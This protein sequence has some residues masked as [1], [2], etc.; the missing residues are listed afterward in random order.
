[1][2][3]NIDAVFVLTNFE[4]HLEYAKMAMDQGKVLV[5][6]AARALHLL[7]LCFT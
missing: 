3:D 2:D 6:R 4:T 7:A 1:M 5:E